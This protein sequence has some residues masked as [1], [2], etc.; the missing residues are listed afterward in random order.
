[1]AFCLFSCLFCDPGHV[2]GGAATTS[3]PKPSLN[4]PF[5]VSSPALCYRRPVPTMTYSQHDY[6]HSRTIVSISK[7]LPD[8]YFPFPKSSWVTAKTSLKPR[9]LV[10]IL[11][12][13]SLYHTSQRTGPGWGCQHPAVRQ[14][15]TQDLARRSLSDMAHSSS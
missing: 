10:E 4:L 6:C 15:N 7:E 11:P 13:F 12:V 14:A 1:M 9:P 8:Q 2:S 5:P 3:L